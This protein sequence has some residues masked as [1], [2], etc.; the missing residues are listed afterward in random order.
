MYYKVLSPSGENLTGN[1]P[2]VIVVVLPKRHRSLTRHLMNSQK[3]TS[4]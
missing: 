2:L 3:I 1:I 4:L